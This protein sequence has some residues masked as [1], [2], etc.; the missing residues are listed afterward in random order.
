MVPASGPISKLGYWNP[1]LPACS[2]FCV[3]N[4]FQPK[5]KPSKIQL[6]PLREKY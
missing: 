4:I 3:K 6:S 2:K 1:L 5:P